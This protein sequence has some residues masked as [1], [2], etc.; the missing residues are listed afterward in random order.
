VITP[1]PQGVRSSSCQD[2]PG[3]RILLG[4]SPRLDDSCPR[5]QDPT[6]A[7]VSEIAARSRQRGLYLF[8]LPLLV[9]SGAQVPTMFDEF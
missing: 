4:V 7:A 6:G 9:F 8:H 2:V 3:Q 5:R 1:Y